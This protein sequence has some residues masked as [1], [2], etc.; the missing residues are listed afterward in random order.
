MSNSGGGMFLMIVFFLAAVAYG[1]IVLTKKP[2]PEPIFL[3]GDVVS[4]KLEGGQMFRG[5]VTKVSC[6]KGYERCIYVVRWRTPRGDLPFLSQDVYE[7]EI[8]KIEEQRRP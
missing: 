3:K 6:Y 7:F 5:A 1:G 4:P 2:A 8:R